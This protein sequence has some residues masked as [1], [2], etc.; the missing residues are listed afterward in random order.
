MSL[1]RTFQINATAT[2]HNVA[3]SQHHET[4]PTDP[5]FTAVSVYSHIKGLDPSNSRYWLQAQCRSLTL[6]RNKW[7]LQR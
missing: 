4:H 1:D 7:M 6:I 5:L 3:C 2:Q